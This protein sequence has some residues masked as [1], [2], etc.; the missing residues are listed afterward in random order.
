[1]PE[2]SDLTPHLRWVGTALL[3]FSIV[4]VGVSAFYLRRARRDRYYILRETAR[5]RGARW[6]IAS[7]ASLVLGTALLYFRAHPPTI[8]THTPTARPIPSPSATT[9]PTAAPTPTARPTLPP[10]PSPTPTRRPTATPP[11]I[12]TPTPAYPLLETAL[13]PQPGAVPAGPDAQISMLTFA[14]GEEGGQPVEPGLEFPPGDHRVYLFFEYSGMRRNLVWTYGWYRE[15]EYL[16]GA[17]RLWVLGRTGTN[18]LYFKPPG[19]YV[20]GVYEVRIW[21]EDRFQGTFQ[22]VI[23]EAQ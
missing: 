15:G 12:P 9:I 10:L 7:A 23:T 20:P 6:L 17:T 5:R 22:F 11:F 14:L 1:V 2:L 8:P 4:S 18:Y 21:I 3:A 19:G 13:T 16:D